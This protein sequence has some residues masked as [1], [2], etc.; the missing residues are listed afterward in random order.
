MSESLMCGWPQ[1]GAD[2]RPAYRLSKLERRSR[3]GYALSGSWH[4]KILDFTI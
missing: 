1:H 3:I 4:W 2:T